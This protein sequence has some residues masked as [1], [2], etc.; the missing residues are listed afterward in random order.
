MLIVL[1]ASILTIASLHGFFGGLQNDLLWAQAEAIN[2][3][4]KMHDV[5]AHF[6]AEQLSRLRRNFINKLDRDLASAIRIA[7]TELK[8][9]WHPMRV[10]NLY[11]ARDKFYA[12]IDI[13]D[14]VLER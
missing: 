11:L 12:I 8:S 10:H 7:E 5:I 9:E 1:A 14:D 3:H 4:K 2:L 13:L 6:N